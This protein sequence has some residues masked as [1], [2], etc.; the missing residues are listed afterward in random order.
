MFG[1]GYYSEPVLITL[2]ISLS[3]LAALSIF[4]FLTKKIS[5]WKYFSPILIVFSIVLAI[6]MINL[7]INNHF[8]DD[9]LFDG[10]GICWWY[11]GII[12]ERLVEHWYIFI[13]F[14]SAVINFYISLS[15]WVLDIKLRK[16]I[17]LISF[18]IVSIIFFQDLYIDMI[19]LTLGSILCP[20][21]IG[22]F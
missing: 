21:D 11:P 12:T 9:A 22:L 6:P 19:S 3:I 13:L 20:F 2:G 17:F 18:I 5:I 8:P 10:D 16:K 14:T 1:I 4:A 7:L 15:H